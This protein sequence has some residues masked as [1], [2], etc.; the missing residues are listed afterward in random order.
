MAAIK[1]L[2]ALIKPCNVHLM[3]DSQYVMKGITLWLDAW[4]VRGWKTA[5]KQPV[6]NI[7]LW[8]SLDEQIN[9]HQVKWFWVKGH[10]GN[11][12]NERADLLANKGI[13][14]IYS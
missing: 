10:A 4:K 12:G 9:R 2:T 3:T 14:T 13:A 1:G 6:K 8:Q 11:L 7:E 5:N